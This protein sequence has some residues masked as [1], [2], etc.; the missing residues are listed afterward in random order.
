MKEDAQGF[1]KAMMLDRL[2]LMAHVASD[3]EVLVFVEKWTD[4][5]EEFVETQRTRSNPK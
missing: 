1:V 3:A 4:K 2:D 5:L